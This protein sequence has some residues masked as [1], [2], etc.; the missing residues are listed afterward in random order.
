MARFSP[1]MLRRLRRPALFSLFGLVVFI[2]ALYLS[3]P[4][5]RAKQVAIRIAATK[6]LDVEIGSASPAFG[7]GVVF[8]D[9][10]VKTK[11][12][13]G[14]PNLATIRSVNS[15][16]PAA[17][18]LPAALLP[19]ALPSAALLSAA[20]T[21]AS[22]TGSEPRRTSTLAPRGRSTLRRPS[23]HI[24]APPVSTASRPVSL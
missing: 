4:S 13:T 2:V 18:L 5:E 12:A 23:H 11:P 6:D 22:R 16:P 15:P 7:L 24:T 1:E 9:I 14:K 10:L 21:R 19:A 8:R 17:A 3:F 20:C